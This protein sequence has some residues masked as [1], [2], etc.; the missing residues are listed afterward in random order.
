LFAKVWPRVLKGSAVDAM[1]QA[2]YKKFVPATPETVTKFLAEPENA[3]KHLTS[4]VAKRIQVTTKQGEK[5]LF[6]EARDR[7]NGNAV[8]RRSY[9]ALSPTSVVEVIFPE[10][11]KLAEAQRFCAIEQSAR[12]GSEGPIL[13]VMCKDK[14]VFV[15]CP[16][17]AA[18]ALANPDKAL[19][20]LEKLQAKQK[21]KN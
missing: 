1:A 2:T 8:I 4:D 5:M 19:A 17:C 11:V 21:A 15:C 13:K 10:D 7:D 6:V 14:P 16:G 3:K 9:I 18:E 20:M 12:L